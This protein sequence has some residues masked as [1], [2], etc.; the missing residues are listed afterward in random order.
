MGNSMTPTELRTL[1]HALGLTQPQMAEGVGVSVSGYRKW[2]HGERGISGP[3]LI[4]LNQ[5][6]RRKEMTGIMENIKDC[7]TTLQQE[8]GFFAYKKALSEDENRTPGHD[9]FQ[10]FYSNWC[11]EEGLFN[12]INQSNFPAS[13]KPEWS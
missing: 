3:V 6:K 5:I 9:D 10:E 12:D 2:E 13:E 7:C 1:R 8:S 11:H 4:L